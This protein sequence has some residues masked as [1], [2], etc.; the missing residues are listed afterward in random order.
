[1][2]KRFH[3]WLQLKVDDPTA[4]LAGGGSVSSERHKKRIAP[5]R[6]PRRHCNKSH[7]EDSG[8]EVE[9][10]VVRD[11]SRRGRGCIQPYLLVTKA[12]RLD[13]TMLSGPG[14]EDVQ[15]ASGEGRKKSSVSRP[16]Q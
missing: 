12:L 4:V 10:F 9:S 5:I 13:G 7:G 14:V 15:M 11:G 8:G 16:P 6:R 3:D 1:M 2:L